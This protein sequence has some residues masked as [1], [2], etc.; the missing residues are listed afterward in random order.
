MP[1]HCHK[2]ASSAPR[3]PMAMDDRNVFAIYVSYYIKVKL[4][5]SAMGGEVSLKLPFILGH[6]DSATEPSTPAILGDCALD[7]SAINHVGCVS[8]ERDRW[9]STQLDCSVDT[10]TD[11][12]T[13]DAKRQESPKL[14]EGDDEEDEEQTRHQSLS[15]DDSHRTTSAEDFIALQENAAATSWKLKTSPQDESSI[16]ESS[17]AAIRR[18]T[19]RQSTITTTLARTNATEMAVDSIVDEDEHL[20]LLATDAAAAA[21]ATTV[22]SGGRSSG[23]V[24][25]DERPVATQTSNVN[26]ITAQIHI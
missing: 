23:I 16:K 9:A 21:A 4:S 13:L 7:V 8:D 22:S 17:P 6:V 2:I 24:Q 3:G 15:T 12:A 5:I 14:A 11:Y 19:V 18:D 10:S 26:V 25:I 20:R 1:E